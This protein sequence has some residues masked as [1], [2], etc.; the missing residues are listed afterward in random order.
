M[1]I[2]L[3]EMKKLKHIIMNLKKTHNQV[4]HIDAELN[5]LVPLSRTHAVDP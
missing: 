2:D 1:M 5:D 3:Q 4:N